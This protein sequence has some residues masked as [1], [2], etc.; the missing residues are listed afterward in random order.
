MT[1][2]DHRFVQVRPTRKVPADVRIL[3][4]ESFGDTSNADERIGVEKAL[5]I[6]ELGSIKEHE[7]SGS[8]IRVSVPLPPELVEGQE[9]NR[10]CGDPCAL[11]RTRVGVMGGEAWLRERLQPM[12]QR[13]YENQ[14]SAVVA[15]LLLRGRVE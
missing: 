11:R 6:V 8:S 10:P 15:K 14:V 5:H 4:S 12:A 2:Y 3:R 13:G 7:V 9:R 1:A